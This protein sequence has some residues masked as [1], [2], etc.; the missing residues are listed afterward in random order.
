M[1]QKSVKQGE[2]LKICQRLKRAHYVI[3]SHCGGIIPSSDFEE[4]NRAC[5]ELYNYFDINSAYFVEQKRYVDGI[6]A[7]FNSIVATA[8]EKLEEKERLQRLQDDVNAI[9][10]LNDELMTSIG[11]SMIDETKVQTVNI[12]NGNN[13]VGSTFG[14]GAT[15]NMSITDSFDGLR[16]TVD[17]Q[18]LT[19]EE[20]EH[21][22]KELTEIEEFLKSNAPVEKKKSKVKGAIGW[23]ADKCVNLLISFLPI[24]VGL[25]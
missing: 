13:I 14:N 2:M 10:S 23:M 3:L 15:L 1:E 20:K 24:V 22:K 6:V 17:S 4:L 7:H 21:I 8:H 16:K 18:N 5:M 11:E 9:N 12:Y 25:L 19:A